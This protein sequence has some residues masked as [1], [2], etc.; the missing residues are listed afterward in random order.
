VKTYGDDN[1]E[2]EFPATAYFVDADSSPG[3]LALRNGASWPV[4]GRSYNGVRVDFTAGYG[5]PEDIPQPLKQ[6]MLAHIAHLYE[7]RGDGQGLSGIRAEAYAP[8]VALS[9]YQS[10]RVHHLV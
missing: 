9:L 6:G 10:F 5:G 8:H 4:P 2:E 7:N 1:E 3:R